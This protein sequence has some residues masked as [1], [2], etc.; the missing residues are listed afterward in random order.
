M[1]YALLCLIWGS[2]WLVIKIGLAGVPPFLGAGLRFLIAAL[3]L[4]ALALARA[5]RWSLSR[6]DRICLLSSGFLSYTLSYATVYW[7][8]QHISSGLTAVL[9]CTM[10]LFT[11]LLSRY[12][13]QS[14]S[15]PPRKAAGIL[16]G[17]AGTALLFWPEESLTGLKAAAMLATLAGSLAASVNLVLLK[18]HS[19]HADIYALNAR[20]MAI[21][22]VCLL[23]ASLATESS[24]VTVWSPENVAALLFLSLF[25]SVTAF[26]I[27]FH[28]I[29]TMDA[30]ALSLITFVTPVI[31]VAL[32]RLFLA[33][34]IS[35]AMGAGM[36]VVLAGIAI[37]R[38][39]V[40]RRVAQPPE[41]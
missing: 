11:A 21:G 5:S 33:E 40:P 10:P 6:D 12:W 35:P 27:Y 31:A 17:M 26:L 19:L 25:G 28:L 39:S 20:A 9:Y 3:V 24:A 4:F 29:K 1:L 13:T 14:E 16:I 15:L 32:G 7:A 18:R 22:A 38:E 8:E 2:T 36:A 34:R 41:P 30:T 37:A 23:A